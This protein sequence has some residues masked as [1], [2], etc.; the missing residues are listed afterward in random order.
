MVKKTRNIYISDSEYN[1]IKTYG[2]GNA[3]NGLRTLIEIA[4]SCEITIN[5]NTEIKIVN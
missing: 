2:K 3:S 1:I 4:N 5:I